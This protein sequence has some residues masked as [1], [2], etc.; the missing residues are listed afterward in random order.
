[1]N[2]NAPTGLL[3]IN[4]NGTPWSGQGR[5]V[6][7]PAAQAG[8]IFI[9]DPLVYLGGSDAFGVPAAGIAAAGGSS[10][11]AG[12]FI[13]NSNGPQGSQFTL[14]Q[15]SPLYR[16]ASVASYAF[17]T[18]DPNQVFTIQEDSIGGAL[19]SASAAMEN[20]DLVAGAGSTAT[21]F[22]GWQLDSSTAAVTATLQLRILQLMR[23]PDNAIGVNA[24]WAVRL[25]L[26]QLWAA[27]GV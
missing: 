16:V 10:V 26:P 21:G 27:L 3:P 19:S 18:D 7:I 13:S 11:V 20:A 24:K 4:D 12:A 23:G 1:M 2:S 8:N 22:S 15:S 14:L 9:G 5:L 25:N 6:Y 17:M